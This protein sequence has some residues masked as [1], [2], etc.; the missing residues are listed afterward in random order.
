MNVGNYCDTLDWIRKND[1]RAYP[2]NARDDSKFDPHNILH[3]LAH[4]FKEY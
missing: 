1:P 2:P 4:V 3:H